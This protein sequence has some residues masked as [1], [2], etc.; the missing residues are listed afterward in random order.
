[1]IIIS[2]IAAAVIIG[3]AI[4]IHVIRLL[5]VESEGHREGETAEEVMNEILTGQPTHQEG[6]EE[7]DEGDKIFGLRTTAI[8]RLT[9]DFPKLLFETCP[10]Y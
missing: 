6:G 5:A 10:P 1:M 2:G 3:L 8:T 4:C 9:A 7:S